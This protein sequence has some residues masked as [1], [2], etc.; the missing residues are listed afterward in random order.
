[1]FACCELSL[2]VLGQQLM[3]P[4]PETLT[5]GQSSGGGFQNFPLPGHCCHPQ[6]K[7]QLIINPYFFQQ[8]SELFQVLIIFMNTIISSPSRIPSVR[9]SH[10][11]RAHKMCAL[12]NPDADCGV[13]VLL[14]TSMQIVFT[15]PTDTQP[16]KT[17][18]LSCHHINEGNN[19]K[20][21]KEV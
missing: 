20:K 8:L 11:Q 18:G 17:P 2:T 3:L 6:F 13:R 4:L 5:G 14:S 7:R 1:M 21:K 9:F 12:P 10:R 15:E 16:M 19:I